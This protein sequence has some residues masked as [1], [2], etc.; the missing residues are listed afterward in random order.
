VENLWEKKVKTLKV[1]FGK[2]DVL[3]PAKFGDHIDTF[4]L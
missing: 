4:L 3:A 1:S 2:I